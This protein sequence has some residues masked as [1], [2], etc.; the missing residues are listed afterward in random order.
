MTTR[1][2]ITIPQN[3][4]YRLVVNIS[5]GPADLSGYVGDM[6]IRQ[7]KEATPALAKIG[8]GYFTVDDVNRQLVLEI[9][10]EVTGGYTWSGAGVYDL[11]IE[12]PAGDRWRVL[13]GTVELSK[14][15]TREEA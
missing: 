3:S 11:Y 10:D 6:D 12:G 4:T 2:N 13:E 14:T 9:P 8:P 5:G 15:V 1:H 7:Y